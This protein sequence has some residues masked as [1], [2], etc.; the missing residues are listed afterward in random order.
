MKCKQI[1]QVVIEYDTD[2]KR[3]TYKPVNVPGWE[4]NQVQVRLPDS[5]IICPD[6][7]DTVE[8]MG[9]CDCSLKSGFVIQANAGKHAIKE[10]HDGTCE[11][12]CPSSKHIYKH[13]IVVPCKN[14]LVCRGC[15]KVV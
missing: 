3:F 2:T 10:N 6:D 8:D 1:L 4:T 11:M 12:I 14:Q 9:E 7:S 5:I 13:K 15:G